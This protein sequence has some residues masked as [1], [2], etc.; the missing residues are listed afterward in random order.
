MLGDDKIERWFALF[1]AFLLGRDESAVAGTDAA[2]K[3]D[4]MF[5][6]EL[7]GRVKQPN[8]FN[9]SKYRGL[10]RWFRYC[11]LGWHDGDDRFH[12]NPYERL[13]RQLRRLY[14]GIPA[15]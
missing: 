3:W 9:E 1:Y 2:V 5:Q 7:F 14:F 4:T 10:R 15:I 6:R 11:G 13:S 12:P 8:R